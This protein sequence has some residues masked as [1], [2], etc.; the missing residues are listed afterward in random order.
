MQS[1]QATNPNQAYG[2][3]DG[4]RSAAP[5]YPCPQYP[6]YPLYL[7]QPHPHSSPNN[8]QQY[9]Q[10]HPYPGSVVGSSVP[11]QQQ[12]NSLVRPHVGSQPVVLPQVSAASSP[13]QLPNKVQM[14]SSHISGPPPPQPPR[15]SWTPPRSSSMPNTAF[16]NQT[17][18]D[19][20]DEGSPE[21]C[22]W[23]SPESSPFESP[24]QSLTPSRSQFSRFTQP[25]TTV[26]ST[27]PVISNTQT[28]SLQPNVKAEVSLSSSTS[29]ENCIPT[30]VA[31][32]K[33]TSK[34]LKMY[35]NPSVIPNNGPIGVAAQSPMMPNPP[36]SQGF[37]RDAGL[38]SVGGKFTTSTSIGE[39]TD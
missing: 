8:P 22:A 6:A 20:G 29:M 27:I 7:P 13:N 1:N 9:P 4:V 35:P 14:Q 28:S 23:D 36:R 12:Q 38:P 32:P 31:L 2:S 21:N 30:P 25:K 17:N 15:Q 33:P 5:S 37:T 24:P 39:L 11:L 10:V 18:S 19:G 34:V 3:H 26:H 16:Q